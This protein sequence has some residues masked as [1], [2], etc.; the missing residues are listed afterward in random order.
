VSS[1]PLLMILTLYKG[2]RFEFTSSHSVVTHDKLLTHVGTYTSV[3]FLFL[4]S[5]DAEQV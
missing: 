1:V 4:E 2:R 3:D 5:T